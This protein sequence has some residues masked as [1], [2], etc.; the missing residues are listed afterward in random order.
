MTKARNR[1]CSKVQAAVKAAMAA[2]SSAVASGSVVLAVGLL[3]ACVPQEQRGPLPKLLPTA[4]PNASPSAAPTPTSKTLST[5]PAPTLGLAP[6]TA[7]DLAP[8]VTPDRAT[9]APVVRYPLEGVCEVK[10]RALVQIKSQ[11]NGEVTAVKVRVGDTVRKGEV[12]VEISP[13]ALKEQMERNQLARDRVLKRMELLTA[14]IAS[15]RREAK[16]Q[17]SLY[18]EAGMAKLL[19]VIKER[20]TEFDSAKL[21]LRELELRQREIERE[22]RYTQVQSPLAGLIVKRTVEPGQIVNAAG[23]GISGGDALL[24]LADMSELQLDCAVHA[25]D[26]DRIAARVPLQVQISRLTGETAAIEV[27]R[28]TPIID[29]RSSTPQLQFQAKFAGA[30]PANVLLGSRYTLTQIASPK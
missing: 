5:P 18:S 7:A 23:G 6:S 3:S 20:E 13:R 11:A 14:Q 21:E 4:S 15:Q 16:I 24:E 12:L 25:E 1:M 9:R 28:A 26:A 2:T 27:V 22:M 19:L 8:N 10:A 17:E 30:V 29:T